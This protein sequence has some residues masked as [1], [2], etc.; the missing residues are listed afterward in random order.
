LRSNPKDISQKMQ[1]IK[2]ENYKET[3]REKVMLCPEK[4]E[5]EKKKKKKY[6][7]VFQSAS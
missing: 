6:K 2:N 7:D 1:E 3:S 5:K 4:K